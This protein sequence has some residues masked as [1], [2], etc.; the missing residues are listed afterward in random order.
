MEATHSSKHH[1]TFNRLHVVISQKT[2]VFI[3]TTVGTLNP[4]TSLLRINGF[5]DFVHHPD[6]KELEDK[7]M[8]FRN[9][10]CFHPQVRGDTYSVGSLRKS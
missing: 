3:T 8:T 10:I 6:C 1:F 5:S 9:W 7:N 2:G 4:T